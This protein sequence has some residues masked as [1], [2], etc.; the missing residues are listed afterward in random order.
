MNMLMNRIDFNLNRLPDPD[1]VELQA[2]ID[3]I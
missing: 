1:D 3:R 2:E